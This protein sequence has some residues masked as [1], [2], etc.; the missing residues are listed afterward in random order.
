MPKY[1]ITYSWTK[2][3]DGEME[4]EANN[5]EDAEEHASA[6]LE[7]SCK[8]GKF[9]DFEIDYIEEVSDETK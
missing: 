2:H 7:S 6:E 4:V 5:V 8:Y 1:N 3:G 9:D